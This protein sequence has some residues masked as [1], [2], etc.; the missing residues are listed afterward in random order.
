MPLR[1]AAN[2]RREQGAFAARTAGWL[3][4]NVREESPGVW[5]LRIAGFTDFDDDDACALLREALAR[6]GT[7]RDVGR[8][9]YRALLRLARARRARG[10][11]DIP[12][13]SARREHDAV[14]LQRRDHEGYAPFAV[15]LAVPGKTRAGDWNV[16]VSLV[17]AQSALSKL[18]G[19]KE[20]E[21]NVTFFD[22]A[23]FRLPLVARSVRTG[24][25]M[26]PFGLGGSKKLSDLFVDRKI[27]RRRREC[28]L[29]IEGGSILWVPGVARSNDGRIG[30]G[31]SYVVRIEAT[32]EDHAR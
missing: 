32:R 1:I 28:A 15:D 30:R 12:G 23:D 8:V 6:A 17:P 22:V 26:R 14:V 2:A 5:T 29:V 27:P 10:A 20:R 24:D 13:F 21:P 3:D 16:D 25:S 4:E 18:M 7:A 19:A 31:T 9:H 11:V